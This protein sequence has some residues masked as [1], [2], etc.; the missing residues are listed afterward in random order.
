MITILTC[1]YNVGTES[2]LLGAED[3]CCGLI[4]VVFAFVATDQPPKAKCPALKRRAVI[5]LLTVGFQGPIFVFTC[6]ALNVISRSDAW[7]TERTSLFV[8]LPVLLLTIA[9]AM[10]NIYEGLTVI[11]A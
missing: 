5:R 2:F 8:L 3:G 10:E 1:I 7:P 11:Y 6:A 9:D 4:A